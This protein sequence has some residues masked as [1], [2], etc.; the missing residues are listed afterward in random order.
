MVNKHYLCVS[1]QPNLSFASSLSLSLIIVYSSS[2]VFIKA[3]TLLGSASVIADK[4]T[5]HVEAYK[6]TV[7]SPGL[8]FPQDPSQFLPL[9]TNPTTSVTWSCNEIATLINGAV[10]DVATAVTRQPVQTLVGDPL[11]ELN[12]AHEFPQPYDLI[13]KDNRTISSQTNVAFFE[14]STSLTVGPIPVSFSE[15]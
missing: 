5:I 14:S 10:V 7:E 8:L 15:L 6:S 1:N 4:P 12:I 13:L 2:P 11:V 3:A 9:V